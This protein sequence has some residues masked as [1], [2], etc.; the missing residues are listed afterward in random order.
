MFF[1]ATV[2]ILSLNIFSLESFGLIFPVVAW[3]ASVFTFVYSVIIVAQTFWGQRKPERIEKP[4]HEAPLGM[5][6][7]PFILIALVVGIFF[8]PNVLRHYVLHPAMLSVYPNYPFPEELT[9]KISPW[10][11]FKPELF[12]TIGV[13]IVGIILYRT[14]KKWRPLYQIFP[15]KYSFNAL[16]ER[17]IGFSE[18]KSHVV[19]RSYMNGQLMYYFVYIYVFF[20]AIV[21]GYFFIS[22]AFSWN[23]ASDA[24]FEY[25][26]LILVIVMVFASIALLFAKGRITAV[27]LNGVLGYSV[28][29]F[30]V[31]FRAPDL[32]LT[33]LVVESVTT[34][35]FLLCFKFL[36]DLVKENV[37]KSIQ[38]TKATISI[39]V[40][41]TVTLVGLAVL[42]YDKFEPISTY[43][44]DSYQLAGGKNIV[45]TILGDFRAFDTMLEVVVLFIAGL[46]VYTLIKFKAK[47]GDTDIED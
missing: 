47:K 39:F 31:V 30:F 27:L 38:F 26:E 36:P 18:S 46:G 13:V 42:N 4:V 40:G 21:A 43:F 24:P 15:Q 12:M 9:G 6:I 8:F 20:V 19:T 45:N 2:E 3:I 17:I 16:Y 41:A 32:A 1:A 44:E 11:G 25:Y 7:S 14:L 10:H 33:Q 37:S 35:L 28:A 5:L 22:D 34:A 23:P 29:F